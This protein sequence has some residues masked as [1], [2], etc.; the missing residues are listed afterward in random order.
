MKGVH[1]GKKLMGDRCTDDRDCLL[2]AMSLLDTT[3]FKNLATEGTAICLG[4][5][6]QS[7]PS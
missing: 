2:T 1:Y 3:A 5:L 7:T 6:Q 4:R